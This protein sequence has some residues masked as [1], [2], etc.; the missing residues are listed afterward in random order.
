LHLEVVCIRLPCIA[1]S[2]LATHVLAGRSATAP[3]AANQQTEHLVRPGIRHW[4]HFRHSA[5]THTTVPG[6]LCEAMVPC[7]P[8]AHTH[9]T[10]SALRLTLGRL[11]NKSLLTTNTSFTNIH[12]GAL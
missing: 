1:T 5:H 4:L 11:K 8:C 9:L 2:A 6:L 3:D 12:D 10:R 7:N